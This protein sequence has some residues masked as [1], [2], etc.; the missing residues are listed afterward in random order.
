MRHR[1]SGVAPGRRDFSLDAVGKWTSGGVLL[2]DSLREISSM[3]TL[4]PELLARLLDEHGGALALYARQWCSVPD[5]VVQ[6]ALLQLIR[7]REVPERIVP[8]LYRVV[9][10][11]AVSMSRSQSRR[12]RHESAVSHRGE[13]WFSPAPDESLDAEAASRALEELPIELRETVVAR[14]WGGLA[15]DEIAELTG[16]SLSTAHRRYQAALVA[17]RERLENP[18]ARNNET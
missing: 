17:L 5:D 15:F 1:D 12:Q 8:W 7:Q 3:S 13:P 16:T 18:C 9:R 10:N 14:V 11:R 6:E 2:I 4:G